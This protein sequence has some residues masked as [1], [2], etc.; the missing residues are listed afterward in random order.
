MGHHDTV[1]HLG[2]H[3]TATGA[4]Q[5]QLFPA[6][7]E[8][9]LLT[10][11]DDDVRQF[12][13]SVTRTDPLFYDPCAARALIEPRMSA[14]RLNLLSNESLSGPPYAGAIEAGLDHRSPILSN[15]SATFPEA[16]AILVL[17][18]QDGLAR[19]FYR[20]YLK[21][22]GTRRVRRFYGM[23][24]GGQPPLMTLDRFR[25]SPYVDAVK[26]AFPHGVVVLAFEQFIAERQAFLD[27]IAAFLGIR[28]PD[29][30][31]RR[32]NA[33]RLGPFGMEITRLLNHLFRNLLNPAGVLPGI[34]MRRFG[35]WRVV[36]PVE[37]IHD[38]APDFG[39]RGDGGELAAVGR[40]IL[41]GVKSDNRRL[42]DCH[43]L[44][45]GKYG[46]F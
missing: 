30:E 26:R 15:L 19:S 36:S 5:R 11:L 29:I 25:F 42:C 2:L 12:V 20:Q 22:G 46:Y 4:L 10:T 14:S 8:V 32:E 45:F 39:R 18:R 7:N 43:G 37:L 6:C 31:L 1:I 3:K 33:T 21:S 13:R 44:D 28:L 35:R 17:R 41:E 9:Q 16:R 40:E 24:G 38:H 27:S 34:P 23:T